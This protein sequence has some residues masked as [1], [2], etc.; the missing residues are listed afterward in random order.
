MRMRATLGLWMVW[1]VVGSAACDLDVPD[2]NA[3][4]LNDLRNNPTRSA[5]ATAVTGLL[6]AMRDEY[7]DRNGYVSLLGIL[8][9]ES[10]NFDGADPRFITEMLEG[11][12]DPAS[13]A[14]GANLWAERYRNLRQ[15]DLILRAVDALAEGEM[16]AEEKEAVR[17]FVKTMMAH[18]LL[19]VV[20]TRDTLGAVVAINEDPLAD[21]AP[22]VPR[23]EAF[24]TVERWLDE[25]KAHLE[26]AGDA[27]PFSLT[28]GFAGFDTPAEFLK[29]NRALRAR[30]AVY[31]GSLGIGNPVT[32]FNEAIAAL[33]ES[34]YTL[35]PTFA[36]WPQQPDLGVYH[37]FTTGSGD[38][39]NELFD[40]GDAPDIVAH[41][42]IFTDAELLP[43]ASV[44]SDST[45]DL[46]YQRKIRRVQ[47]QTQRDL[48]TDLAFRIYN[49][50]SAP[51]PIIR[52]E[53]LILLRAEA[54]LGRGNV[55]EAINL[56]DFIRNVSGGLDDYAGPT[57]AASVLAE[58]LRQKRYSLL[59]EGGHR[60]IDLRRYGR[61]DDPSLLDIPPGQPRAH[62]MNKAFPIPEPECLA[63][64]LSTPCSVSSQ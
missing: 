10:Y 58:L 59:F 40:P 52:N 12:L 36:N 29:V 1:A 27:F 18:E 64:G 56:I 63:R 26:A 9:R 54:E 13:P 32:K 49:S 28:S 23:S 57:D 3:A 50:L 7:D 16:S 8:G 61:L 25:G 19:L 55:G 41:P 38:N 45:V 43:G 47:S 62:R 11:P 30:V 33:D 21:P 15:G 39:V 48:T 51:M 24:L 20:N 17:G 42:S 4:D 35:S 34:F 46:R 14:F 44:R 5:V 2:F 22:L 6:V 53:E 31:M 60:W 37:V